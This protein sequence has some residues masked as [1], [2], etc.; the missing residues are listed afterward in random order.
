M[1]IKMTV[2]AIVLTLSPG[3][4]LAMGCN[5]A[6]HATQQAAISC[7]EGTLLDVET[8]TCVPMTTG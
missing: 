1:K 4:A 6:S 5:G 2:A 7:A 3:L 8:N